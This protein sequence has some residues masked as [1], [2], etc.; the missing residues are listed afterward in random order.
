MIVVTVG[1]NEAP[2][3]RLLQAVDRLRVD[4]DLLVQHGASQVRPAAAR[5]VEFLPFD[6]MAERFREARVV[7]CHAGVGS[8]LLALSCGRRPVVVPRLHQ[9]GEAVDDHQVPLARRL[10]SQNLVRLVDDLADLPA[11]LT[12]DGTL[13]SRAAGGGRLA[14]DVHDY[15]RDRLSTVR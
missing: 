15:I 4:E 9:F 8:I 6:E 7:V 1:T 5:C 3:D 11:A 10:A 14:G 12:E 13:P 2:F